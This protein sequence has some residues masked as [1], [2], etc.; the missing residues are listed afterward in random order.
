MP[1]PETTIRIGP[2]GWNYKDWYSIVYPEKPGKAFK[3][4]DYLANFFNTAEINSTFY[5]P[6]NNFMA[7]AWVRKVA[8][9]ANF[10]FTAKLWNRFTHDRKDFGTDEVKLYTN[11]IDPL[12]MAGKL[13]AVLCQFPWS[14][15]NDE[16]NRKW[17]SK[18]ITTFKEYPTVVEL[19]HASWDI[20]ST[21]EFLNK[22]DVGFVSIDQP[23]IGK[24]IAFKPICTGEIGYVRMHGRNYEAW[25]AKKEAG[26]PRGKSPAARYDYLYSEEEIEEIAQKVRNV[27]DGTQE[28]YVIQNN[29][30]WGQAVAN[31]L[32]LKAVLG[33]NDIKVPSTMLSRFPELAKIAEAR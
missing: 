24:S 4:L 1:I 26:L 28:T 2:A 16:T 22:Q 15:K 14:F 8:H 25:F 33:E 32:Q 3:E 17:L 27:A 29:H 19:R 7:S 23:V 5:R 20:P 31:A 9:N 21:Y 13:G 18:I 10:K 11:G 6:A 30:P 12:A